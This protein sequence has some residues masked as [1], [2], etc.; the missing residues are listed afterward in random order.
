MTAIIFSM[1]ALLSAGQAKVTVQNAWIRPAG[2]EMNSAMY[3]DI[4]NNSD[5]PDTLFKAASSTAELVQIHETFNKDGLMGMR[6]VKYVVVPAHSTLSFKPGGYHVMFIK[7]K[8]DFK[9]KTK[10]DAYLFFKSS[11]KIK[12]KPLVKLQ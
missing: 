12:I 3:F 9:V 6:E 4:V 2:K 7:L 10:I 5:K 8:R 11:G 1:L